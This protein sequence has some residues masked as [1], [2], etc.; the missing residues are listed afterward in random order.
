MQAVTDV[1]TEP[2]MPP[3]TQRGRAGPGPSGSQ[4]VA[5]WQSAGPNR[6][7]NRP[8][9]AKP[10]GDHAGVHWADAG[11][12]PSA[13]SIDEQRRMDRRLGMAP[14]QRAGISRGREES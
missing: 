4:V 1:P 8:S 5:Q 9:L 7:T 11:A 2:N 6:G 14:S 12:R 13:N 3:T 10:S